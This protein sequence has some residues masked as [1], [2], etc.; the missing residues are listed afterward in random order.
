LKNSLADTAIGPDWVARGIAICIPVR[1]ERELLPALFDALSEQ[2]SSDVPVTLCLLFDGC[3]DGSEDFA[4]ERAPYLP[5]G[6]VSAQSD[7][8]AIPN[9]GRAR[10]LAMAL[11]ERVLNGRD[12]ALLTTDADSVP[13]ADWV[14][15][16]CRALS[17]ADVVAGRIA[18]QDHGHHPEQDRI[19][20]YY[21]RLYA[22]RRVIDPLP[23]EAESPHHYSGGASL[24]FRSDA[25]AVLG[26]FAPCP[27]GE[28]A[29]I[30][31]AAHRAGLRV[32]RDSAVRV[33]TSSRREG[34]AI[35]G[36]ADHLRSIDQADGFGVRVADPMDAIWQYRGHALARA[37][38]ARLDFAGVARLA[39]QLSVEV[40]HVLRVRARS[41]NE[42]AFATHVVPAAPGT[43]ASIALRDAEL[44]LSQLECDLLERAA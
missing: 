28:D 44:A 33:K 24:A 8:C 27:S 32:R 12:G 18:R 16:T 20:A 7:S 37:S 1:N 10:R 19:E 5:F 6:V 15:A 3:T 42:E 11:G 31:D 2:S 26:G 4:A 21:D 34:R 14:A 43:G 36:L 17:V 22:L 38:Y 29:T 13:A 9:A 40:G 25:Y 35:G 23:W 39:D 41:P 30:V